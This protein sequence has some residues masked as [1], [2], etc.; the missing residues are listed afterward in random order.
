MFYQLTVAVNKYNGLVCPKKPLKIS[1]PQ[2]FVCHSILPEKIHHGNYSE[3]YPAWKNT[4]WQLFWRRK[5]Y[6]MA[7]ILKKEKIHH[8]NYSE[9]VL[10]DMW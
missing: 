8:G 10:C 5:K 6:N 2:Q 3:D 4:T 7:T 9:E 1:N